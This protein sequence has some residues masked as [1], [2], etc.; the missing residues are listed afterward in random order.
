VDVDRR[1]GH[2][3]AGVEQGQRA[4][5][6]G[7]PGER[8]H[9]VERAEHVRG[10]REGDHPGARPDHVVGGGQVE[11]AVVGERDPAQDG[12]RTGAGPLPRHEVRVV[13]HLRDD[14]LVAG[15]QRD[16]QADR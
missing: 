7:L 15:P 16:S 14:D 5:G 9:G 12:A 11:P 13:L 4:D 10:V 8:R 6:P 3:L 2:R 1:V